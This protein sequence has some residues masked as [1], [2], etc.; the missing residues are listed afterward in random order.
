MRYTS[1]GEI[2]WQTWDPTTLTLGI[3]TVAITA[4]AIY[5]DVRWGK[6]FNALTVPVVL[7]GLVLNFVWGGT[8]GLAR[9][10]EGIGLGLA[11]FLVSALFGRLLGGGD[12]K[13]L[14]AMGALQGP[15]FL[16]WTLFYMA[17]AGAALAIGVAVYHGVLGQR[18]RFLVASCYLRMAQGVP[19][20][21]NEA[22]GGPRLPY[23]IAIGVGSMAAFLFLRGS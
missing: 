5:T 17:L 22:A 7:A 12:V 16:M 8:A 21:M 10:A 15:H 4:V 18:L 20:E 23:A 6:I 9:S 13:L 3:I 11:L 2:T 1:G 14:M 19:M